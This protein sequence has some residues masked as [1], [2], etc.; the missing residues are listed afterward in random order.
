MSFPDESAHSIAGTSGSRDDTGG[1][2][3]TLLIPTSHHRRN[4]FCQMTDQ[5]SARLRALTQA[6]TGALAA[7]G[8][9]EVL[10]FMRKE[11]SHGRVASLNGHIEEALFEFGQPYALSAAPQGFRRGRLG[12]CFRKRI[13]R[14]G[15]RACNLRGRLCSAG[16]KTCPPRLDNIRW[17]YSSRSHLEERCSRCLFGNP[18]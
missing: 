12:A 1:L 9:N 10:A 17:L 4:D 8:P 13:L 2:Y 14:C 3:V 11:L 18:V 6:A 5:K 16:R 15:K 7:S